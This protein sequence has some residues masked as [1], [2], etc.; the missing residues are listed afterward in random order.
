MKEHIKLEHSC[1]NSIT[2]LHQPILYLKVKTDVIS[3]LWTHDTIGYSRLH[4]TNK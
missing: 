2:A 1:K 4:V 3:E